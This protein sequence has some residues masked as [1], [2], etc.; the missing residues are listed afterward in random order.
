MDEFIKAC[1][2]GDFDQAFELYSRDDKQIND[3]LDVIMKHKYGIF[4]PSFIQSQYKTIE[5]LIDIG[6]NM[7]LFN[8]Y[9]KEIVSLFEKACETDNIDLIKIL[10]SLN[11][12]YLSIHLF[13]CFIMAFENTILKVAKFL[14]SYVD[15]TCPSL[16]STILINQMNEQKHN[17]CKWMVPFI[18]PKQLTETGKKYL[19]QIKHIIEIEKE[20]TMMS[21]VQVFDYYKINEQSMFTLDPFE[22]IVKPFLFY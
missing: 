5:W 11:S 8:G 12:D 19:I 14:F 3:L 6:H 21:L 9:K 13:R 17:I 2:Y 4:K 16:I 10:L 22:Y 20:N 15:E 18:K 7:N 1:T